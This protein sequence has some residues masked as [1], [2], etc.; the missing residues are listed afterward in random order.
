[1]H[2]TPLAI[3]LLVAVLAPL[4]GAIVSGLFLRNAPKKAVSLV[5]VSAVFVSFVAAA[6]AYVGLDEGSLRFEGYRWFTIPLGGGQGVPIEF[7]LSMDALSGM[8]AVMVAGIA[9]LIHL[10][11]VGY[12]AEEESYARYFAYLNLF[13][14]AMQ[15][16]VLA[17]NLPLLFVGWEGVGL[18][19][20]L[21][22]GFWHQNLA[23]EA[24]ARKAFIVNRVGDVA[25]LVGMFL[26]ASL[27]GTLDFEALSQRAGVFDVPA[28][29]VLG[30]TAA[31][32][33]S[34]LFFWGATAKS[35]QIPLYVWLPDAMAGPTPVSALIHAA[36]M[37]TS[38]VYLS[39]RMSPIFVK[40]SAALTVILLVGAA[41]ALLAGLVALTQD[42]MKK[43]LAFSTVSQ[44]GFMFA[45]VGVGAFS[46]AMFHVFTHA[47]F[48]AL[49][50]LGAG[51]VMHAV[52]AHGDAEL[53]RLGGLRKALPVTSLTFL[54]G[55]LSLA[56]VPLLA[57]FFSKEQILH[58]LFGAAGNAQL[59][60]GGVAVSIPSW[61]ATTAI[62][63]LALAA[64]STAFYSLKLYLRTFTGEPRHD[65]EPH[66]GGLEMKLPLVLLAVGAVLAGYLWLP[67]EGLERFAESLRAVVR[68]ALPVEAHGGALPMIVGLGAL[69]IGAGLAVALYKGKAEDPLP[70]KL[71][72]FYRAAY[73][74][75][76]VDA[77]YD[78]LFVRPVA[79]IS[80]FV[81]SFDFETID[82]LFVGIP[83]GLAT[84]GSKAVRQLQGS[85]VHSHALGMVVGLV[86]VFGYFGYPRLE[87]TIRHEGARTVLEVPPSFGYSYRVDFGGDGTYETGD[88]RADLTALA[89]PPSAAKKD[90]VVLLV[91][92][93][94][95]DSEP[96]E[97][98]LDEHP[99]ELG[100]RELG[101]DFIPPGARGALPI[102][103]WIEDGAVKLR[104]NLPGDEPEERELRPG[105][106][107]RIGAARLVATGVAFARVE[108]KNAFGH[109]TV[110][111]LEFPFRGRARTAVRGG[112]RRIP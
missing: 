8:M 37:V 12:M 59:A 110:Q 54:V 83:S 86:L 33:V 95:L 79:A 48:K 70:A 9:T 80:R 50:F 99:R 72:A 4:A 88:F 81:R 109:V 1:M 25:V 24:A 93:E 111:E 2:G 53:D 77:L 41:T 84:V 67:A 51:S 14:F 6:I 89:V 13:T 3:A 112:S 17:A 26:V 35:A 29:G 90:R 78:R 39:A 92:R 66:E 68:D 16:L 30:M 73:Q 64:L 10:F 15:L 82:G 31:T 100:E 61:A 103:A 47:F 75:F 22:I 91:H 36:T 65:A 96:V 105:Q 44:L 19:S 98:W 43:V 94:P 38:G 49:L 60:A 63:F 97:V 7:A 5:S 76:G 34:L 28:F 58:A 52:H 20:Y 11:S 21:L 87:V 46:A 102:M 42:R 23:Y 27:T 40:S 106:S 107:H 18:C 69:A 45:A 56:G 57:G 108:V 71:G 32:A 74:N 85:T 62:V 101:A 55:A 104:T